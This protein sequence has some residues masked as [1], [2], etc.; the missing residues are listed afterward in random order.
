M[1]APHPLTHAI[2]F[3]DRPNLTPPPRQ[4]LAETLLR[5]SLKKFTQDNLSVIVAKFI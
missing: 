2:G 3:P 1:R 4:A 5:M